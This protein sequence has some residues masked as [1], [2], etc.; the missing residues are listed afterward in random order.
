MKHEATS[1]GA[2][3]LLAVV[4]AGGCT[5]YPTYKT[6]VPGC[7]VEAAYD[8]QLIDAFE[9]VGMAPLW[10]AGDTVGAAMMPV[11]PPMPYVAA[12]VAPIPEG[13]HCGSTSALVLRS[14]R[15]NDWGSLF[16]MNNFGLRDES[17]Y[18]GLSFWARVSVNSTNA[19]TIMLDDLNTAIGATSYCKDYGLDG[20]TAGQPMTDGTG[21]VIPGT[22]TDA[23]EPDQCGNGYTVVHVVTGDWRFY[24]IPFTAF[25]Q[26]ATPNRVPNRLLTRTGPT[27]GTAMLTNELFNLTFRMPK[28]ATIELW[29]DNLSF[30][31]KPTSTGGGDGGVDAAQM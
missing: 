24:T 6:V 19:F 21:A 15:N 9:T 4:G 10:T 16:G 25:A 1:V 13:P 30:Y 11:P 29:I 31:R 18:E 14:E 5:A 20:G 28:A 26:A 7:D 22:V 2:L 17:V 23:P 27:P 8:L 3:L 12:T